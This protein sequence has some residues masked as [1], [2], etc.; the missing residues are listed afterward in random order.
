MMKRGWA[1]L[2]VV[3]L[4]ALAA[5][6]SKSN[7]TFCD[8]ATPCPG[9][10]MVCDLATSECVTEPELAACEDG[11]PSDCPGGAAFCTDGRCSGCTSAL[12]CD[13]TTPICDVAAGE[14]RACSGPTDCVENTD[15]PICADDGSCIACTPEV[16]CDGATPICA[17]GVCRACADDDECDLLCDEASGRCATEEEVL[18]F[19]PAAAASSTTCTRDAPC[20]ALASLP[21]ALTAST[22]WG[23]FAPGV[24][25]G[26][27]PSLELANPLTLLAVGATFESETASTFV[28]RGGSLRV[29]HGR[30]LGA[31]LC[32]RGGDRAGLT[33]VGTEIESI[34]NGL[35]VEACD[36]LLE[37]AI[38]RRMGIF[39]GAQ[40][41]LVTARDGAVIEAHDTRI[42]NGGTGLL[43]QGGRVS[44]V[45]S[46]VEGSS[47]VGVDVF[48]GA[49]TL[50][51]T[52]VLD[53]NGAGVSVGTSSNVAV[54]ASLDLDAS[55]IAGNTK[56]G[57][58]INKATTYDVRNSF[59]VENG[60]GTG[61]G[62]FQILGSASG[63]FEFNTVVA[64]LSE[65]VDCGLRRGSY[66]PRV[67]CASGQLI[68]HSY[69][70]SGGI[71]CLFGTIPSGC[72]FT[73]SGQS[74]DADFVDGDETTPL[75]DYHLGPATTCRGSADD[76]AT[77]ATD[78]D[79]ESR[80][81]GVGREIGADEIE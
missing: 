49:A 18:F 66:Q 45:D 12:G 8:G 48:N 72:T 56:T 77:L 23:V 51:R 81:R 75:R 28:V 69:I 35:E 54:F 1:W 19:D 40:V 55:V 73:N 41:A 20:Q 59:I 64:N 80:P 15:R 7:P 14:C 60:D 63:T 57:L 76:T 25:D 31:F 29:E 4:V 22:R 34:E 13:G 43:V 62:G 79:G 74:C 78:Y 11:D 24:Y 30:F 16:G 46:L 65:P 44:L 32:G 2:V 53:N 70:E 52:R 27:F 67:H 39:D 36:A 9:V 17:E 21:A 37:G 68:A 5:C 61:P 71:D 10:G 50:E 47:W 3:G 26:P 42:L 38:L 6:A 58:V 33:L